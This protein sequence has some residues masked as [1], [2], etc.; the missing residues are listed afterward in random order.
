MLVRIFPQKD[1][2]VTNFK[3]FQVPQTASNLGASEILEVYKHAEVSGAPSL[4]HILMQF[5]LTLFMQLTGSG[6][7]P[8]SGVTYHLHMSDAQHCGGLPYSYDLE[9]NS[10]DQPWDEGRGRDNDDLSDLGFANWERSTQTSY[11]STFG[12]GGTHV[13]SQHLDTGHEDLDVDITDLVNNWFLGLANGGVDNNGVMV[14]VTSS[15]E[16]SVASSLD[17]GAALPAYFNPGTILTA[18]IPGRDYIFKLT[19]EFGIRPPSFPGLDETTTPPTIQIDVGTSST[20]N[21]TAVVNFINSSVASLLTATGGG[22]VNI[23]PGNPVYQGLMTG[24]S[25]NQIDLFRKMF[26][27]RNTHFPDRRPYI[28]ARWDDHIQDDRNDFYWDTSGTLYLYNIVRGQLTD[29]PGS[30]VNVGVK[31]SD[32][33]GTIKYVTGSSTGQ[34]GIYSA[35][36]AVTTGSYSGSYW[37]DVWFN[38]AAP[39]NWFMT[40]NFGIGDSFSRQDI[41]PQR[42]FVSLPDLQ[43]FYEGEEDVRLDLYIR[44]QDYDPAQVLTAS[45]SSLGMVIPKAYYR[46]T[47]DRTDDVVVPFSTGALEY[48][49]LSYDQKGNW[50]RFRPD[51]LSPGQVYRITFLFD[52]DGQRQVIDQD[53]KFKVV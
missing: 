39:T 29:L 35:S 26:H 14:Q 21:G 53:F 18:A 10:L 34:T 49:R 45:L 6:R 31:L 1:T 8:T 42:Y 40:G 50:F 46:I 17:L 2:T 30:P 36:F 52:Q 32:L 25:A 41:T 47:N 44:P 13:T 15:Q 48:T 38:L 19:G 5:D 24:S 33:S 3:R 16:F 43:D 37:S 7:M 27:A 51:S 4:A 20:V 12:G 9:V 28:E 22:S 23:P 11:W